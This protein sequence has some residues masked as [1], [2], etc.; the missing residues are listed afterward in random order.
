[1]KAEDT[2]AATGALDERSK[3][4]KTDEEMERDRKDARRRDEEVSFKDVSVFISIG[5]GCCGG[6]MR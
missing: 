2:G 6:C 4:P 5:V 3:G 1:M